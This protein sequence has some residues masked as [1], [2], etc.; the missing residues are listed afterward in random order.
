MP[1]INPG[2]SEGV[3]MDE[4][5]ELEKSVLDRL[6]ELEARIA[7]L[8][9]SEARRKRK[10]PDPPQID[11]EKEA[12]WAMMPNLI[13]FN[14][15]GLRRIKIEQDAELLRK[16]KERIKERMGPT[17]EELE[18]MKEIAREMMKNCPPDPPLTS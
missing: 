1:T 3:S 11:A 14:E 15:E 16:T 2:H 17:P 6:E 18:E 4:T 13:E 10:K 9:K 12:M 5:P 8:E 7:E